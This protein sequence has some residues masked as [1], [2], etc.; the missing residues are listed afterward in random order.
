MAFRWI[1]KD[2]RRDPDNICA[3]AKFVMDALVELGRI[4]GDTRR[5]VKGISHEFPDP[6]AKN[7]RI[8]ITITEATNA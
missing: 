2:L 1:E 4:P 6:D 3:G 8:E 5:W 7:P